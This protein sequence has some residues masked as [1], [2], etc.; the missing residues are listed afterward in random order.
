MIAS[1]IN[2]AR[3]RGFLTYRLSSSGPCGAITGRAIHCSAASTM[4]QAPQDM[5]TI[6]LRPIPTTQ[7]AIAAVESHPSQ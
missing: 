3:P 5:P 2:E 1:K 4:G 6:T 7:S